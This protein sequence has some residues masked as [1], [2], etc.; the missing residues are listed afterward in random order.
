M[1]IRQ[2]TSRRAEGPGAAAK[3]P[4]RAGNHVF[5]RSDTLR[6]GVNPLWDDEPSAIVPENAGTGMQRQEAPV[7][8]AALRH[9][10]R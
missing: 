4:E 10:N 2:R 8:L 3:P 5:R 7:R 6:W 1:Q 9:K